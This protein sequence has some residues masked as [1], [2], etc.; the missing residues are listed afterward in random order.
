MQKTYKLKMIIFI[1]IILSVIVTGT[2]FAYW[3]NSIQG[4]TSEST[5][6]F[7]IGSASAVETRFVISPEDISTY[8]YLVPENQAKN[9]DDLAVENIPLQFHLLWVED[10]DISQLA[11]ERFLGKLSDDISYD[12]YIEG[13][14]D[15]LDKNIY[16]SVYDLIQIEKNIQN[17]DQI[18]LDDE[19]GVLLSYDVTLLE[20]N[21]LKDYELISSATIIFYFNFEVRIN[22]YDLYLD[23]TE[24]SFSDMMEVSP[25]SIDMDEWTI[26]E[27]SYLTSKTGETRIFYP[28]SLDTYTITTYASLEDGSN[29]GYGVFFDTYLDLDKAYYDYGYVLQF[30]RGYSKGGII[31]RPRENGREGN[32]VWTYISGEDQVMQNRLEDPDWWNSTHKISVTVTNVSSETRRADIYIDDHYLGYF[33]YDNDVENKTIYTG[34]RGWGSYVTEYESIQVK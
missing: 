22:T 14:D 5:G 29:G 27:G 26:E 33:T 10:N 2:S 17:Q 6:S 8:G 4:T 30:D 11:G 21:T 31:V 19:A 9:S 18:I 1:L 15:I 25:K 34:F 24:I 20:P 3:F 7:Q 23:F 12:I 13:S 16:E 28:I 32:P